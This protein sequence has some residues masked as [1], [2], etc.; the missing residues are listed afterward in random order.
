L[1]F[2]YQENGLIISHINIVLLISS[3]VLFRNDRRQEF[4]DLFR[5]LRRKF[6][7][8]DGTMEETAFRALMDQRASKAFT[9]KE[10]DDNLEQ[11]Y[12]DGKLM[13]SD[14]ILYIID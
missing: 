13:K 5:T 12:Q 7:D 1:I 2:H 14:G 10:M 3:P 9:M 6:D 11:L 8:E 4:L